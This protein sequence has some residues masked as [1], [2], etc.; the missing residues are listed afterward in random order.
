MTLDDL[1]AKTQDMT[2]A[3]MRARAAERFPSTFDESTGGNPAVDLSPFGIITAMFAAFASAVAGADPNDIQGPEDLPDMLLAFIEALPVVG[4]FVELGEAILG[5]YDGTDPVLLGIQDLFAPLRELLH[6]ITG[7]GPGGALPTPEDVIAG[8]TGQ[9]TTTQ[10]TADLALKLVLGQ[11]GTGLGTSGSDPFEGA[12]STPS[13][14][15]NIVQAQWGSA[16]NGYYVDGTGKLKCQTGGFI[17]NSILC[18]RADVTFVGDYQT[19]GIYLPQ[20]IVNNTALILMNRTQMGPY[21]ETYC[22][23]VDANSIQ[24]GYLENSGGSPVFHALGTPSAYTQSDGEYWEID[25]GETDLSND[26]MIRVRRNGDPVHQWNDTAA[27]IAPSSSHRNIAFGGVAATNITGVIPAP[28]I[29][30][31][32]WYERV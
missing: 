25:V 24:A 15:P 9:V 8:W 13:T 4:Q 30:T 17:G 3:A 11:V 29:E 22:A 14:I 1:R 16:A 28:T 21:F 26:Y 12:V 5:T 18:Y 20:H 19:N 27:T 10:N 31:E 7:I 2:A 6:V 32:T 23:Y